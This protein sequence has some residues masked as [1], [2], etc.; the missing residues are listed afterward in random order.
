MSIS[1][2]IITLNEEQN[3]GKCIS[4]LQ[5]LVE[6]II[7]LDSGSTD[8]TIQ[9]SA[10]MGAIVKHRNFTT[11][12]DQKNEAL[13]FA[14]KEWVFSIDADEF[15]S[16]ELKSNIKKFVNN[17][18]IEACSMNRKTTFCGKPIYHGGWYPDRKVR[19]W[20]NGK[21]KWGGKN[22]HEHLILDASVQTVNLAGDLMHQ[23]VSSIEEHIEKIEYYSDL[24]ANSLVKSK[25]YK[26]K[27]MDILISPALT[28]VK[29]YFLQLGFLDGYYG[30]II[31][32]NSAFSKYLKYKKANKLSHS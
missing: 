2:V 4:S 5:G 11:Y 27:T 18:K 6:E 29:K 22:P 32:R 15:P 1:A 23:G 28:F 13:K 3:I 20:K 16:D 10:E 25:N 12:A 24:A 30:F 9:I 31:A 14:T 21:A 17:P 26:G 7:V 8:R 19:L